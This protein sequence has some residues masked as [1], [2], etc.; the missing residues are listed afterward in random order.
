[1]KKLVLLPVVALGLLFS[2][3]GFAQ[4]ATTQAAV[5]TVVQDDMVAIPVENLPEAITNA[6]AK[7]H[8]GTTISEAHA[9]KD[10]TKFKLILAKEDGET[11]TVLC[12]AEG[13]W[14][15]E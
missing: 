11:E 12:D 9:S 10:A 13:N 5:E 3:Q 4:E 8:P 2:A 7:D 1:M 15:T 6:V 14:I